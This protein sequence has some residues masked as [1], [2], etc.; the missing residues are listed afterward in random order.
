MCLESQLTLQML[1]CCVIAT[2][3][4]QEPKEHIL[5]AGIACYELDVTKDESVQALAKV[6]SKLANGHLHILVNNA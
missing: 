3:L 6:T 2:V 5:S 4:P 1:G